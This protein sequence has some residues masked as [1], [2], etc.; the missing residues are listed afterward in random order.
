MRRSSRTIV[1]YLASFML[2]SGFALSASAQA[3]VQKTRRA[4][5]AQIQALLTKNPDLS[6]GFTTS[7]NAKAKVKKRVP[8]GIAFDVTSPSGS[9]G[10]ITVVGPPTVMERDV[11]GTLIDIGIALWNKLGDGG[12]GGGGGKSTCTQTIT[13]T[14]EGGKSTTTI[15]TTCTA[16]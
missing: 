16:G 1:L 15:T 12:G 6:S 10:T 3:P 5:P 11:V 13:S 14:V 2:L 7:Q 4:T 9:T 8:G